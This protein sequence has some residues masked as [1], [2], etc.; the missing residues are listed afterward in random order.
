MRIEFDENGYDYVE[1]K[2]SEG[3]ISI[4]ISSRDFNNPRSAI[5]NSAEL[6]KEQFYKLISDVDME[7]NS[8]V[9]KSSQ[10]G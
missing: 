1:I 9:D 4:V 3:G 8:S 7:D 6:T 2:P 10:S 5:I